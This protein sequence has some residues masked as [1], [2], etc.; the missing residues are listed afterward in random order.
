MRFDL[1]TGK[2]DSVYLFRETLETDNTTFFSKVF[3]ENGRYR[4]QGTGEN[5]A[6]L[7]SSFHRIQSANPPTRI[8]S[9]GRSS[10][11]GFSHVAFISDSIP[12]GTKLVVCGDSGK[13]DMASVDSLSRPGPDTA[14]W[15]AWVG[16]RIR[17][18]V[19]AISR[20]RSKYDCSPITALPEMPV[21]DSI[22]GR[23]QQLQDS[24]LS[25]PDCK[26]LLGK[27]RFRC[28]GATESKICF[29]EGGGGQVGPILVQSR[30]GTIGRLSEYSTQ[31]PY[32][33][34]MGNEIYY[35]AI[36]SRCELGPSRV[37]ALRI[38]EGVLKYALD[39]DTE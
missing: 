14:D 12:V 24:A 27:T 16:T 34:T 18:P 39:Y 36:D 3:F 6:L 33:L 25:V 32:R 11:E 37:R 4:Y 22:R 15:M 21:P 28:T 1:L 2:M 7:D 10:A 35:F 19:V 20:T 26:S 9:I 17:N 13:S 23:L 29:V 5:S 8:Y 31:T 30:S 38:T